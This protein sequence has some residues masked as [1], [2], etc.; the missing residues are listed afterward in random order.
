MENL[1]FTPDLQN[2]YTSRASVRSPAPSIVTNVTVVSYEIQNHEIVL[3]LTWY[4]PST[5]NGVLA[6][7]KICA[8]ED[9]LRPDEEV[10]PNSRRH[11]CQEDL[12][13]R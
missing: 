3:E 11:Q 12:N 5:P 13:V 7:Y 4:P 2:H 8:G 9:P 6:S 10:M 1:L